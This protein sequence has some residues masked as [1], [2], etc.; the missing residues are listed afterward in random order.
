MAADISQE[1]PMLRRLIA[2]IALLVVSACGKGEPRSSDRF[3]VFSSDETRVAMARHHWMGS[4]NIWGLCSEVTEHK[5]EHEWEL[6]TTPNAL[7]PSY[8]RSD[9]NW[10][11]QSRFSPRL[12][13]AL[14]SLYFIQNDTHSYLVANT[15]EV[16]DRDSTS[17][18]RRYTIY[19][20]QLNGDGT[21]QSPDILFNDTRPYRVSCSEGSYGSGGAPIQAVPSPSGNHIVLVDNYQACNETTTVHLE[22][23]DATTLESVSE[24][25]LA[26][27]EPPTEWGT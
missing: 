20:Y 4:C 10:G 12:S 1:Y 23:F 5:T 15:H 17:L 19:I 6:V 8:T 22:L 11:S 26:H 24:R 25:W 21:P 14:D 27:Q 3:V 13:G 16:L 18:T 9:I 2:L 7:S